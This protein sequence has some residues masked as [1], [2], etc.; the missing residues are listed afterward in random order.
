MGQPILEIKNLSVKI[1]NET[2]LYD[3]T[4]SIQPNDVIVI[5]GP[6]GAG[7]TTLLRSILNLI[8]HEGI[9]KWNAKKIGYLPPH[10][11]INRPEIPPQTI[12]DFFMCKKHM[13]SQD[14][15]DSLKNVGLNPHIQ[16]KQITALSTGQFQRMLVAWV[17]VSSPSILLLDDPVTAIDIEGQAE[18]YKLLESI[19]KKNNMTII[20]ITHNLKLVWDHATKVI[21]LDK[22]VICQGKPERILTPENLY[23]VYGWGV[24]PY[25]HHHD[26]N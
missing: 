2:I 5:I 1:N 21:C 10:E 3:I 23:K 18:I 26:D 20:L 12:R 9:V 11:S 4:F 19:R 25:E 16:H 14:I 15:T 6:N 7:K 8:P 13:N 17:L 22:K 24:K